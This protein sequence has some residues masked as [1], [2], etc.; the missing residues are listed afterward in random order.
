[1]FSLW[2][3]QLCPGYRLEAPTLAAHLPRIFPE[4][5]RRDW[6]NAIGRTLSERVH[7]EGLLDAMTSGK[8]FDA[9]CTRFTKCVRSADTAS[10]ALLPQSS[11]ACPVA[12]VNR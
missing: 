5:Q 4:Y 2:Q 9:F 7:D 1:M 12:S 11:T 10:F 3:P 6:A 8:T